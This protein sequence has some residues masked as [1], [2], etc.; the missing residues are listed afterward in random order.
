MLKPQQTA[1]TPSGGGDLPA[2]SQP[3]PALTGAVKP[4]KR[5]AHIGAIAWHLAHHPDSRLP[6][7]AGSIDPT[8]LADVA[9][10]P[11]GLPLEV[12]SILRDGRSAAQQIQRFGVYSHRVILTATN[13]ACAASVLAERIGALAAQDTSI[14]EA[15]RADVVKLVAATRKAAEVAD[16]IAAQAVSRVANRRSDGDAQA[17]A[18]AEALTLRQASSTCSWPAC[19]G[20]AST[21]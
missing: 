11:G 12:R 1:P 17:I 7:P 6:H 19:S 5:S 14:T 16:G 15:D 8:D 3:A 10:D 18:K 21:A 9:T 2:P 20:C 4:T 13:V